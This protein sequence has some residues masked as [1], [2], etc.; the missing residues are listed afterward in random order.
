MGRVPHHFLWPPHVSRNN[1]SQ[2][3]EFLDLH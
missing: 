1:A 2:L 3:A